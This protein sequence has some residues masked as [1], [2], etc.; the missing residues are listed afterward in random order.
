MPRLRAILFDVD[1][2]L[3]DTRDAWVEAFDLGLAAIRRPVMAGTE[4]ARW[5]GTPIEST[6]AERCGLSGEDLARAV[7]AFREAELASVSRGVRM[8][9]GIRPMLDALDAWPL[10]ALTNKPQAATDASFELVGI[11][12]R[13]ALVLGGDAVPRKKPHPDAVRYAASRLAVPPEACALVG[14]SDADVRAGRTAGAVTVGVT[15]GY[16]T[17]Q[18]LEA[19]GVGFL[20]EA[21]EALPPLLRALTPSTGS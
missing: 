6:Y 8:F 16:G 19:E 1:G 11:R 5:I 17:R 15:W 2:T 7:A 13:F 4:A 20:I 9:P 18:R 21:P 12:E 10:A 14:D 3:L